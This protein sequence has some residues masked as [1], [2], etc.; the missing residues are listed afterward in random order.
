MAYNRYL[1]NVIRT[2]HLQADSVTNAKT[3]GAAPK[4]LEFLYDFSS[5]GGAISSITLTDASGNAQQ[6]P[7]N[8]IITSFNAHVEAAVTSAGSATVAFGIVGDTDC[9]AGATAKASLG[10][11]AVLGHSNGT[12]LPVHAL[13]PTNVVATVATAA[14]TAGKIKVFVSYIEV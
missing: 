7:G 14:L 3:D 13:A 10:L 11:N 9:F 5:L 1:N 4:H 8:S 12:G 6:I 2:A